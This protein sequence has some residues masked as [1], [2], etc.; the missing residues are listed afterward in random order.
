MTSAM[1]R[2]PL[3]KQTMLASFE[4]LATPQRSLG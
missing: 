1:Q 4:L 3:A 2:L